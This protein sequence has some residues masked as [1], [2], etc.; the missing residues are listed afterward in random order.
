MSG[1]ADFK[2][3]ISD[4][5][6]AVALD[7]DLLCGG[8]GQNLRGVA[9]D[10]CPECGQ[11]FDRD[12]LVSSAIPWETRGYTGRLTGFAKTVWIVTF[13]PSLLTSPEAGQITLRA[14]RRFRLWV[15]V[16]LFAAT[17]GPALA[18]FLSRPARPP[19]GYFADV[20]QS[21]RMPNEL[22]R[23]FETPWF[24]FTSAAAWL[25]ALAAI[26]G[27]GSMFFSPRRLGL[28]GQRRGA[29]VSLYTSALLLWGVVLIP[30]VPIS[31]M[32]GEWVGTWIANSIVAMVAFVIS[33]LFVAGW[34]AAF[35][36]VPCRLLYAVTE[37]RV[38]VV[39]YAI[40]CPA[41]CAAASLAIFVGLH[42]AVTYVM[43]LRA[44][45]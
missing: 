2:S 26:T 15:V 41:F 29:A 34:V 9:A 27:S 45:W 38:R 35:W 25:L 17:F 12:H 10:R 5:S 31:R 36:L 7:D 33:L 28:D 22:G 1:I 24:F 42:V 11:R 43:L 14:A 4:P 23:L 6:P 32:P 8:C 40:L 16:L 18:W 13:R 37:S 44:R 21:D 19:A 30:L 3:E 20:L 39:I